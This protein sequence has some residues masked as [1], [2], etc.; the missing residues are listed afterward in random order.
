MAADK[1]YDRPK[2]VIINDTPMNLVIKVA[3]KPMA[4]TQP[5]ADLAI[6][7]ADTVGDTFTV[8]GD[9]T[10]VF[11]NGRTFTVKGSTGNDGSYTATSSTLTAGDT[12]ISVAAVPS[13][14]AD[15]VVNAGSTAN[16][17][18]TYTVDADESG[19]ADVQDHA[20]FTITPVIDK[21]TGKT[22]YQV[23]FTPVKGDGTDAAK[24]TKVFD[25]DELMDAWQSA[26]GRTR[27][28]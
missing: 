17:D 3:E 20:R 14:T 1:N 25:H 12:V 23:D 11:V 9:H 22:Q 18:I 27:Q 15:G 28:A 21:V 5:P 6:L 19:G 4:V 8:D 13:A 10:A 16:L 2:V 24:Q 7:T 26:A